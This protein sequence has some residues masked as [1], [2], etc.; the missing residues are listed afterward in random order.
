MGSVKINLIK[1]S[2]MKRFIIGISA[3]VLPAVAFAAEPLNNVSNL[4]GSIGTIINKTLP[5]LVALALLFF[6]YGLVRF[7]LSGGDESAKV[8]A[9]HTMLWGIVALFVMVSVWGL[10]SFLGDALGIKQGQSL[11]SVPNVTQVR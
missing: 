2:N 11:P 10:V 6:F 5:I 1:S 7:I 9:K 3:L 8:S 4:I